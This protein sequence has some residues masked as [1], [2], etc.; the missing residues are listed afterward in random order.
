MCRIFVNFPNV[1]AGKASKQEH[2]EKIGAAK[3]S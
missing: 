1:K 3:A 2:P